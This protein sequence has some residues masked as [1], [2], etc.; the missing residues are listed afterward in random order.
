MRS[1]ENNR[2]YSVERQVKDSIDSSLPHEEQKAHIRQE[3]AEIGKTLGFEPVQGQLLAQHYFKLIE[4]D[5]VKADNFWHCLFNLHFNAKDPAS[6]KKYL[7]ELIELNQ[8]T[9]LNFLWDIASGI[10]KGDYKVLR[11]N[12]TSNPLDRCYFLYFHEDKVAENDDP[13]RNASLEEITSIMNGLTVEK[14][15]LAKRAYDFADFSETESEALEDLGKT[16]SN[17]VDTLLH[18]GAEIED[19][20]VY[21][22]DVKQQLK[23]AI[24]ASTK[25]ET[26][27]EKFRIFVDG[28]LSPYID[29]LYQY[30]ATMVEPIHNNRFVREI[31][32]EAFMING[33]LIDGD[34]KELP[35]IKILASE[36]AKFEDKLNN[37]KLKAPTKTAPKGTVFLTALTPG[38]GVKITPKSNS[39]VTVLP[40][41]SKRTVMG[42]PALDPTPDPCE[43]A[44]KETSGDIKKTQLGLPALSSTPDGDK[45]GRMI[46]DSLDQD[47]EVAKLDQL[48]ESVA[49][50]KE[51][52]PEEAKAIK[53]I[54]NDVRIALSTTERL[55]SIEGVTALNKIFEAKGFKKISNKTLKRAFISAVLLYMSRARKV[56]KLLRIKSPLHTYLRQLFSDLV[57]EKEC[58]LPNTNELDKL[59]KKMPVLTNFPQ[60]I[61][62]LNKLEIYGSFTQS[63]RDLKGILIKKVEGLDYHIKSDQAF[64]KNPYPDAALERAN[65]TALNK[66]EEIRKMR[67]L[68]VGQW[69]TRTIRKIFR[70]KG[71]NEDTKEYFEQMEFFLNS[72]LEK[73]VKPTFKN[74]EAT[75]SASSPNVSQTTEQTDKQ[76]PQTK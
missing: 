18:A 3:C 33:W 53:A 4:K 10:V 35:P 1:P 72:L 42:I 48:K 49:T 17:H 46:A 45:V 52:S 22:D 24:N 71:E 58:K 20:F 66:I 63:E 23:R 5:P 19:I 37:T 9:G 29:E 26:T 27:K 51:G 6:V 30:A 38:K 11:G 76:S 16:L 54:E 68:V 13:A 50:V 65:T 15:K 8:G 60:L 55:N 59:H 43:Q 56:E 47:K 69:G 67:A 70:K 21:F 73:A 14:P 61:D 62:I 7:G 57:P 64:R 44:Q 75:Y 34:F 74:I 40:K 32:N 41:N 12:P 2:Q 31:M 36:I 39:E 25:D 28:T